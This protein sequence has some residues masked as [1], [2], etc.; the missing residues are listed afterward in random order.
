MEFER[1][2]NEKKKIFLTYEADN[3]QRRGRRRQTRRR[4]FESR[5]TTWCVVKNLPASLANYKRSVYI[6]SS[7]KDSG[8]S[9]VAKLHVIKARA[10]T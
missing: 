4:S 10:N 2:Y 7:P 6:V 3:P 1:I 9:Y 5:G 8:Q